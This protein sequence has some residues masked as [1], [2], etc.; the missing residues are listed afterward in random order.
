MTRRTVFVWLRRF[1]FVVVVLTAAFLSLVPIGRYLARAAYEEGKILARRQPIEALL[2]DPATDAAL[3]SKL[4]LVLD[5]RRF[6]ID[7]LG[8]TARMS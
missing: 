2:A 1:V 3:R 5:A 8:L 6:A 7:S 4:R